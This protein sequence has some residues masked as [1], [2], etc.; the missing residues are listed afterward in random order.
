MTDYYL[1]LSRAV[2]GLGKNVA[3]RRA[4]YDRARKAHI[5][6]LRNVTPPLSEY[7]IM[8]ECRTLEN[9]IDKVERELGDR[10]I[11]ESNSQIDSQRESKT[12][13]ENSSIANTSKRVPTDASVVAAQS[14]PRQAIH[15]MKKGR[16]FGRVLQLA[17]AVL[18][19]FGAIGVGTVYKMYLSGKSPTGFEELAD[20]AGIGRATVTLLLIL[21]V[22]VLLICCGGG[23]H[24]IR[25]NLGRITIQLTNGDIINFKGLKSM[26][27]PNVC[28]RFWQ[29][30]SMINSD[31]EA[32]RILREQI[33]EIAKDISKLNVNKKLVNPIINAAAGSR[34]LILAP[35]IGIEVFGARSVCAYEHPLDVARKEVGASWIKDTINN[36]EKI[37][38][39]IWDSIELF[40]GEWILAVGPGP[41]APRFVVTTQRLFLFTKKQL[42]YVINV[43][44]VACV[45]F[46][47]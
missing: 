39:Y 11:S 31:L 30:S 38:S 20:H 15:I 43:E 41:M 35:K 29:F 17:S 18:I 37:Q 47:S 36:Y 9:A 21:A 6:G 4:I 1:V 16:P 5:G 40:D 45:E 33:I 25:E 34:M 13:T 10:G 32:Y 12:I 24:A 7:D 42:I 46:A 2:S 19:C 28:E 8:N 22:P 14:S 27:D 44:S 23:L 26:P 3:A